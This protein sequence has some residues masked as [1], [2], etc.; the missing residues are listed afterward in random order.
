MNEFN[1]YKREMGKPMIYSM[2][3]AKAFL[4]QTKYSSIYMDI[5]KRKR[6]YVIKGFSIRCIEPIDEITELERWHAEGEEA[7]KVAYG[8]RATINRRFSNG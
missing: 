5:R 7:V 4:E 3:S 2:E 8:L 6:F 1:V